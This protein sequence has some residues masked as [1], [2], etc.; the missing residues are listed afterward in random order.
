MRHLDLFSGIGG[1]SLASDWA[2]G[3][4]EHIFCEID[5]FCQQ[6][7]KKHWPNST[8]Y[9]DIKKLTNIG[10]VDLVTGGFPCQPF[11]AAGK[12]KGSDDSRHLWPEMR[13]VIEE[14]QPR[15][16]VGENVRGLLNIEGGV[17]FE[18]VC[19]DLEALGYEVQPFVVPACAVN[20]PHR[21]DRV[22]IVAHAERDGQPSGEGTRG[23]DEAIRKKQ[24]WADDPVNA[25][26]AGGILNAP[27]SACE[28]DGGCASQECGA[29]ERVMVEGQP[30]GCPVRCQSEGRACEPP[31]D[32]QGVGREWPKREGDCGRQPEAE[33]GDG[34]CHVT[35]S[36]DSGLQ[37]REQR[38]SH[39]ERCRKGAHG[40]IAELSRAW[41]RSWP[42]VA[43]ELCGVDDGLSVELDGFKLT[44]PRHRI[45]RLKSLGNAIVP[46]VAYQILKN[47]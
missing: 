44:K 2:F 18:Q 16:V 12:R 36:G 24:A 20:A 33:A 11:S 4:V 42:E 3:D 10:T 26:G 1:F 40:S 5:P 34:D 32:T 39:C 35:H 21:R 45:E 6:I 37:R 14:F 13:R 17:V 23:S 43:A 8:I 27:D 47:L 46:A 15:W 22:W 9:G 38:G 31:A 41:E 29:C 30:E 7:L 25:S 19:L 28:R